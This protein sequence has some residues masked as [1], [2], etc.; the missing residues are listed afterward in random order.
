MKRNIPTSE[1]PDMEQIETGRRHTFV[2]KRDLINIRILD[3]YDQPIRETQCKVSYDD[4]MRTVATTDERGWIKV[5]ISKTA[6]F[7]DITLEGVAEDAQRRVCL[8]P[9]RSRTKGEA[10][11]R[12]RLWNLGFPVEPLL[13]QGIL[14]FQEE[15]DLEL[16]GTID[17]SFKK[18][19]EDVYADFRDKDRDTESEE[20][21]LPRDDDDA[22]DENEGR[23]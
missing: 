20:D 19:L 10:K 15:Y 2:L 5:R 17:A 14:E 4:G 18:K 6:E 13:K 7:A 3:R 12:Q 22:V 8:K 1:P 9:P 21:S 11:I 23:T 16:T